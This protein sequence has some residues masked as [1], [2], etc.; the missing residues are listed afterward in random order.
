[1]HWAGIREEWVMDECR[2]LEDERRAG[3]IDRGM[4]I[5][6][7]QFVSDEAALTGGSGAHGWDFA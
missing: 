7:S 1:M 6:D 2:V 3:A 5:T 4:R